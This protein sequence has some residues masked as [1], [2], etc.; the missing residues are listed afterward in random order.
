MELLPFSHGSQAGTCL[1]GEGSSDSSL[2][3]AECSWR[4]VSGEKGTV[5][6]G[7]YS[8]HPPPRG[9]WEEAVSGSFSLGNL[10]RCLGDLADSSD[11]GFPAPKMPEPPASHG[12]PYP[13]VS[14]RIGAPLGFSSRGL[15]PYRKHYGS[16]AEQGWL[17][18]WNRCPTPGATPLTHTPCLA[19]ALPPQGHLTTGSNSGH[20]L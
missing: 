1:E 19:R 4:R 3:S 11:G 5:F 12:F 2:D 7:S 15:L 9:L 16:R 20:D 8:C 14:Y 17:P 10:C 6:H 13:L 18:P